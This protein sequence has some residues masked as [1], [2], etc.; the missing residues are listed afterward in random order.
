MSLD[1]LDKVEIEISALSEMKPVNSYNEIVLGTHGITLRKGMARALYL[2]QVAWE[3]GWEIEETLSQL[4][5]KAG[6]S[7]DAWK[8]GTTFEVFT[9]QVFGEAFRDL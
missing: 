6:L 8:E 9:A 3:A 7:P 5:Q 2:P 1:E 4:A